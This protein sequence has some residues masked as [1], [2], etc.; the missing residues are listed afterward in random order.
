MDNFDMYLASAAIDY[1]ICGHFTNGAI[2]SSLQTTFNSL[3]VEENKKR[4][5]DDQLNAPW[6]SIDNSNASSVSLSLFQT[7]ST[8]CTLGILWRAIRKSLPGLVDIFGVHHSGVAIELER[9]ARNLSLIHAPAAERRGVLNIGTNMGVVVQGS[10]NTIGAGI[11]RSQQGWNNFSSQQHSN[12]ILAAVQKGSQFKNM[13]LYEFVY[14]DDPVVQRYR[15]KIMDPLYGDDDNQSHEAAPWY[16]FLSFKN[17]TKNV[18]VQAAIAKAVAEKR[19]VQYVL[20]AFS[21]D[22][23]Y[24]FLAFLA[25]LK[26][27]R[28]QPV[29]AAVEW[30]EGQISKTESIGETKDI[31]ESEDY[32]ALRKF[33]TDLDAFEPYEIDHVLTILM[34]KK[35]TVRKLKALRP[36]TLVSAGIDPVAA[37]IICHAAQAK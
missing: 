14:S 4:S 2:W 18:S 5:R 3:L 13:T 16:R 31:R 36:D 34:D 9:Q 21:E 12:P 35:I 33:L 11:A 7:C 28:C 15:S 23:N 25:D 1:R 10:G 27:I 24:M 17:V 6:G 30:V 32:K 37:D 20:Q 22:R 8:H 26:E 19:P 29:T